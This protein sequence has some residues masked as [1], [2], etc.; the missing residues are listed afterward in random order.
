MKKIKISVKEKIN[1]NEEALKKCFAC[2]VKRGLENTTMRML[3]DATKLSASSLYYRFGN[4]D[5]II[6]YAAFYGLE[7]ITIEAI[8]AV[9]K[10]VS[11]FDKLFLT[12]I[13]GV[14]RR[15]RQI[16]LIYQVASSPHYGEQFCEQTRVLSPL[17][18]NASK[19]IAE[20]LSC[21]E[22]RIRP[23][24]DFALST[25]RDFLLWNDKERAK[26]QMRLIYEEMLK[27]RLQ[28]EK[29]G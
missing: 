23:Y 6:M 21:K 9:V 25:I 16:R 12:I 20:R 24:L 7:N 3:C 11:D 2:L 1:K 27:L 13:K 18:D 15:K 14:E 19:R 28:G 26:N 5:G 17:Y 29:D 10:Q 4:K 8:E 22:E